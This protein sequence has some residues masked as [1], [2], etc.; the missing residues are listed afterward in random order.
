MPSRY[1]NR[2]VALNKDSL[3][4]EFF[5]N[6][7]VNFI[8]QYVSPKFKKIS[9]KDRR[10][11]NTIKHI[12]SRG[13]RYSKLAEKYYNDPKLWWIIA[14]YNEKPFEPD[15]SLGNILYIPFPLEDILQII[16]L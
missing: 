14:F 9:Q 6:R 4:E 11:L 3:Y 16:E 12:W 5:V 1:Q 8:R 7:D 13:D 10:R 15:L 2:T